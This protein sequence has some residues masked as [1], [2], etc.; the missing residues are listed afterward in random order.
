M[1][2]RRTK[3][4]AK[5]S[6]T[7]AVNDALLRRWPL[8]IPGKDGD[9]EDRGRVLVIGGSHQMPGAIILAAIAALRAGAG[10][11]TIATAARVA[12]M[13]AQAVCESR[14]IGLA[15]TGSG[16]FKR[17]GARALPD[18]SSA[19]LIGP[20]M[21]GDPQNCA[22]VAAVL[23]RA[24]DAK[25]VLDA[26]A[27]DVIGALRRGVI[28]RRSTG[29]DAAASFPPLLLTPHAGELAHLSGTD[30]ARIL[31]D[32]EAAVLDA[33]RRWNAVVALKGAITFIG[34]PDGRLWRH[35]GGNIGLATSGSGD[36]LSGLIA[37]LAARGATIEQA[38]AWGVALHARAGN[39]LAARVGTLGYLA[40]EIAGE[41][42]ALMQAL[43]RKPQRS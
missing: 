22:F 30:K 6:G 40:R 25:I 9:K 17:A 27:M 26:G 34:A 13:V 18:D 41:L 15:E 20:G 32:P 1:P 35:D 3:G 43:A 38:G 39:A 7:I 12:P 4:R 11:L 21:E 24:L 37:G 8:P 31:D 14:V 23:E 28:Q 5:A 29:A 19:V 2:S 42:P 36:V 33:A 16:S 10:K